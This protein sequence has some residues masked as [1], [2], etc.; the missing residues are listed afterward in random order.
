MHELLVHSWLIEIWQHHY[1]AISDF[2]ICPGLI[3]FHFRINA[4]PLR[5]GL[6]PFNF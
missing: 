6:L 2:L 3:I 1:E 5:G 4:D